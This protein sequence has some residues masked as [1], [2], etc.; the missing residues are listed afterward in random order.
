[1]RTGGWMDDVRERALSFWAGA[2]IAHPLRVLLVCVAVAAGA[3]GY[4][5]WRLDFHSDRSALIDPALDWQQ[6]YESYK[7]AF[8]NWDDAIV[9]VDTGADAADATAD[10]F[11]D[12]LSSALRAHPRIAGVVDGFPTDDAP[13]GLVYSLPLE[14]IES[15]ARDLQRASPAMHAPSFDALLRLA[16]FGAATMD[17]DARAELG[18]LL[19]RAAD[20]GEGGGARVLPGPAPTQRFTTP[21]G[22]LALLF[23]TLDQR[24]AAGVVGGDAAG[25]RA[26]RRAIERLTAEPAFA[27]IEAGVTGVP[28]LETDETLQSVRDASRASALGVLLIMLLFVIVYRGVSVPIMA[29]ASLML[30]LLCA[31]GWATL[32]VG[33]LQVLSVVF[34]VILVGLGADMAI[35][36][37]SRLEVVHPD[38]DHMG[39]AIVLAFRGAGPGIVTGTLTTAAAFAATGLTDFAGVAEL[40]IIAAGGIVLCTLVALAAFPSMLMLLPR[41]EKRLRGRPGGVSRPFMRGKLDAIDKHAKVALVVWTV[42]VLACAAMATRVRYDTDLL[43]LLPDNV[44]SVLWERR[45]SADDERSVWHAVVRAEHE[46][47]ARLLADR[48]R[49]LDEVSEVGG[50]GVL[51]PEDVDAKRAALRTIPEPGPLLADNAP[52]IPGIPGDPGDPRAAASALVGMLAGA[53]DGA[54]AAAARRIGALDDAQAARLERVFAEDR[55]DLRARA[56]ALRAA[57]PARADELPPALR[58]QLVGVD[59]SYLLRV[60]PRAVEGL[61]VL[62]PD[63]L[64]PFVIAVLGAAPNATGPSV[65]IYESTRVIR[66]ANVVAAALAAFVIIVILTI[67]FRNA[68][69]VFCA[70]TPVVVAIVMLLGVMGALGMSLNFANTIVAPLI[71]GLGVTAGVHAVHRWRQQPRD[72]P[73]GLAGGAGRAITMTLSTTTIGFAC[74]MIA[75]HRGIRSLGLVMTLGL[76]M[77]WASTTLLLPAMLRVR[78]PRAYHPTDKTPSAREM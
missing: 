2:I 72:R 76:V 1:M 40:G 26:V 21:S 35:H 32:G 37:I 16:A 49:G 56:S 17:D 10:A 58:D 57:E 14:T 29:G 8:P 7:R 33:H 41:P 22:R 6:R 59:G 61:S 52:G 74:M 68:G 11:L 63:R 19:E 45:L 13:A 36:L 18:A 51:F 69:D 31:F 62:S 15:V 77:V 75:E 64:N 9:V 46:T 3:A 42:I 24:G 54:G 20:A 53:G 67:D 25:V 28:V 78:T 43:A 60:Y 73:A 12:A 39:P 27:G 30:G 5:A 70:L 65:Q 50:A 66:R 48:L 47:E 23:V 38:H 34:M 55:A 44:E 4:A 71:L